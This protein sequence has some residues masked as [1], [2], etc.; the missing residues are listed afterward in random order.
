MHLSLR[1]IHL[2]VVHNFQTDLGVV[3]L[4]H[5]TPSLTGSSDHHS[6]SYKVVTESNLFS[7]TDKLESHCEDEA[8]FPQPTCLVWKGSAYITAKQPG[9]KRL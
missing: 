6:Y 7:E 9:N 2:G 1:S 4:S 3:L 8:D 5:T